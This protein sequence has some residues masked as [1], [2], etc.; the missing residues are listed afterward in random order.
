M[1]DNIQNLNEVLYIIDDVNIVLTNLA[2]RPNQTLFF[3]LT[4]VAEAKK[5]KAA[6]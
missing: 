2:L 5:V 4:N 6:Y 1:F 3:A